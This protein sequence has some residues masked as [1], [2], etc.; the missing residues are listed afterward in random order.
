MSSDIVRDLNDTSLSSEQKK[1]VYE[2]W[3]VEYDKGK[4][5]GNDKRTQ[6]CT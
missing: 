1:E 5:I 3:S 6:S 2:K 4:S